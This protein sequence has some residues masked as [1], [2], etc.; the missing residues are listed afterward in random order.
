M[1][2][3][4]PHTV[5]HL[6]S[7]KNTWLSLLTAYKFDL[8]STR[9][10]FRDSIFYNAT[11]V[12]HCTSHNVL[13]VNTEKPCDSSSIHGIMTKPSDRNH[14]K[15]RGP[16]LSPYYTKTEPEN[17]HHR[18]IQVLNI[19]LN[20]YSKPNM[21]CPVCQD[22]SVRFQGLA[23]AEELRDKDFCRKSRWKAAF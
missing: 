3:P 4:G 1:R 6:S 10:C 14:I 15:T 21:S 23:L 12:L 11:F 8:E 7:E 5:Q 18:A 9:K 16:F 2:T 17:M 20:T 19:H 13:E 22:L